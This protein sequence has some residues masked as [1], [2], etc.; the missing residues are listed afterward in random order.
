MDINQSVPYRNA[1]HDT[2]M[3]QDRKIG[4]TRVHT[5]LSASASAQTTVSTRP[6]L[7]MNY[8]MVFNI[9]GHLFE[10]NRNLTK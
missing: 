8:D 1:Q 2:L 9:F 4:I 3:L 7:Q 6:I 10:T 5:D